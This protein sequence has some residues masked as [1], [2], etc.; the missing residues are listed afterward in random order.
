M[1]KLGATGPMEKDGDGS[2]E[3]WDGDLAGET[4]ETR[5]EADRDR[6]REGL[7]RASATMFSGPGT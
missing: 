1:S 3:G 2:G 4:E 6:T 7:E 5:V